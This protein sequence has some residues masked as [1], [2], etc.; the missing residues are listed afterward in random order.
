MAIAVRNIK[1]GYLMA[2][3]DVYRDFDTEISENKTTAEIVNQMK[4]GVLITTYSVFTP[5]Q[6][7]LLDKDVLGNKAAN[8]QYTI[9]TNGF[10]AKIDFTRI[11][12]S[13]NVEVTL[14]NNHIVVT[15]LGILS[16]NMIEAGVPVITISF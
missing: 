12:I 3:Y 14:E 8:I 13:F 1:N 9:N 5:N 15:V 7:T 10:I 11:N 2:S 4:S 16:V 6:R